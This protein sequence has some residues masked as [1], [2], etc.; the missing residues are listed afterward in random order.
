M[1]PEFAPAA[2]GNDA[3]G[4][5]GKIGEQKVVCVFQVEDDGVGIT[6]FNRVNRS[7]G[8]GFRRDDGAI[9]HGVDGPRDVA[10]GEGAAVMEAHAVAQMED[11]RFGIGLVPALGERG[12]E[13]EIAVASD[14]AVEEQLVDMFRLSIRTYARVKIGG[15]AVDEEYDCVWIARRGATGD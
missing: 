5:C 4:A 10:R 13:M 1:A 14:E 6:S 3:H 2:L 12:C 15:A 9:A 11:E 7:I 8:C